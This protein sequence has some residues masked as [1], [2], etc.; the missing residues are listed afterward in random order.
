MHRKSFDRR[1]FLKLAAASGLSV[2]V[3]GGAARGQEAELKPGPFWLFFHAVGGWDPTM[4]CD[5]KGL[6]EPGEGRPV[7]RFGSDT[8]GE[9]GDLRYAPLAGHGAF[10]ER[11]AHRLMVINGIDTATLDHTVGIRHI[12]SGKQAQG[13]PSLAA[14][15]AAAQVQGRPMGYLSFGGYDETADVVAR[16]RLGAAGVIGRVAWPNSVAGDPDGDTFHSRATYRRI[17]MAQQGRRPWLEQEY[18]LPKAHRALGQLFAARSSENEVANLAE[19]LTM[20]LQ[21]DPL[22]RQ[23]QLSL[24]S[25]KAEIARTANLTLAGFDTHGAHDQRQT[26]VMTQLVRAIDYAWTEAEAKGLADDLIVVVG[27]DFAR[28]P[29]YNAGAGKDHW[30]I[31]SM[32]LMGKG[33]PGGRVLG[34]TSYHQAPYRLD[35]AT[36]AP[37]DE[38]NPPDP[39]EER[40]VRLHPGHVHRALRELGGVQADPQLRARFPLEGI[41]RLPLLG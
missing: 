35:P 40:G 14:L 30:S 11:H 15:V 16:T 33:I 32:L 9:V 17:L 22:Q 36:L 2:L 31:T 6:G 39:E 27:S 12:F 23:V 26:A 10:F 8:I 38:E 24:A 13:Y 21:G 29:G 25:F 18:A 20:G 28:T 37:I 4:L 5:P 41:Q 19:Q 34:K 7:N 3:P 1:D